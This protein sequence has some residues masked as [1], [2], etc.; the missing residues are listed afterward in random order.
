[1]IRPFLTIAAMALALPS[2]AD[3]RVA[4]P[5]VGVAT[6]NQLP[7]PLPLPYDTA[8]DARAAVAA[9][10]AR[11][12][13]GHKKLLID[14]GGNWCLDCRL[15]AGVMDLPA[16]RGFMARHYEVVAVDIG[17]FDKNL[18][19]PARYGI[20]GRLAGVPAL[21]VVDPKTDRVVNAGRETA[22]ADARSLSPQGLADWLAQW[23]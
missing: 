15:L 14:M 20:K 19:I 3:A 11:A 2:V 23:V 6:L 17:R 13:K 22:L 12:L 10:K 4:A 7:Q 1:M 8:A 21:L 9:A 16:M 5:R 18:D